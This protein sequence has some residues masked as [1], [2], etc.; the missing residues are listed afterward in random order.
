VP[1]AGDG[2]E[3]EPLE[4]GAERGRVRRGVLDELE[5]VGLDRVFPGAGHS[6]F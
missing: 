5:A 1:V 2:L 4:Q 3:A 6:R